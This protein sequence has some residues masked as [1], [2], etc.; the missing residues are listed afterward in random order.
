MRGFGAP[1]QE[2]EDLPRRAR[3]RL[4]PGAAL[5]VAPGRLLLLCLLLR[6]SW[7]TVEGGRQIGAA[8]VLHRRGGRAAVAASVSVAVGVP[9]EKPGEA[10]S[11]VPRLLVG[12]ESNS[13]W[14]RSAPLLL[15]RVAMSV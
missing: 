1:A 5:R 13:E 11:N 8:G 3:C 7:L 6:S 15:V 12:D 4:T 2:R 9:L 10:Q 14:A